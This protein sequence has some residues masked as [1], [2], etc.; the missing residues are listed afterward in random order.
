MKF[1]YFPSVIA[2]LRSITLID[3]DDGLAISTNL[4]DISTLNCIG[5][6][7]PREQCCTP[8]LNTSREK[9]RLHEKR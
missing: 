9:K 6:F 2:I 4:C 1:Y 7:Y 3:M 8:M 5:R